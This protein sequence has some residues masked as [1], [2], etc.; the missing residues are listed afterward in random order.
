[1][2]ILMLILLILPMLSSLYLEQ[3]KQL[4]FDTTIVEQVMKTNVVVSIYAFALFEIVLIG[5]HLQREV[6]KMVVN[7]C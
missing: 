1:M 6:L 2:M 7:V 5:I 3:Q 4:D